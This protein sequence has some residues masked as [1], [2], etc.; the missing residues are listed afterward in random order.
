VAVLLAPGVPAPDDLQ[1]VLGAAQ[2]RDTRET[3]VNL[4]DGRRQVLSQGRGTV[5]KT[6]V[7]D[8]SGL[9]IHHCVKSSNQLR[10]QSSNK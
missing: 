1:V 5:G 2:R 9:V 8:L 3:P 6:M 7:A 10:S 4:M